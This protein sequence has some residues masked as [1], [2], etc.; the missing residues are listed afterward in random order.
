MSK[1]QNPVEENNLC[2][3][4]CFPWSADVQSDDKNFH[5]HMNPAVEDLCHIFHTLSVPEPPHLDKARTGE[6]VS[7]RPFPSFIYYNL[8]VAL[9]SP[10]ESKGG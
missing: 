3:P 9:S 4:R 7:C 1:I 6:E 10:P 8:S 5:I 2:V